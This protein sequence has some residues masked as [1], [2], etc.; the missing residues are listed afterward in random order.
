[1][2]IYKK[3]LSII[4]TVATVV[5]QAFQLLTNNNFNRTSNFIQK[6]RNFRNLYISG[7]ISPQFA[8]FSLIIFM[9]PLFGGAKHAFG[10]S[11]PIVTNSVKWNPGHY[12]TILNYGKNSSRYL[13]QIY[14][15]LQETPALRG[16]QVNYRWA[17]LE[18]AEGEYDFSSITQRLSELSSMKKR[19]VIVID[20]KTS[21][22]SDEEIVPQYLKTKKYAGGEFMIGYPDR[23]GKNIK[24]WN[25]AVRD[26]LSALIEA[27]GKRFNSDPYF[28]GIGLS[29][30]SIGE[31]YVPLTQMQRE[32]YYANLL[33]L[34]Q[35]MR[36]H[37]PNTLTFQFTS[38]PRLM[39][40][41]FIESLSEIGAGLGGSSVSMPIQGI[42]HPRYPFDVYSYFPKYSEKIPLVA[43]VKYANYENTRSDFLGYEPTVLE[44][45]SFARDRLRANYIFWTRHPEYYPKVLELLNFKAQRSN[46]SGGLRASCPTVY[47]FCIN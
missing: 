29:D 15:E 39:L 20:S 6:I 45:L 14:Q 46:P 47:S 34:Q 24:L 42:V 38:Y 27:L 21:L 37:F 25:L 43:S 7:K 2:N 35:Q 31:T 41:T 1:M 19:L 17:E 3:V 36:N 11:L 12:Y 5:T 8:V 32:D 22:D 44:L 28:E 18:Q 40:K 4:N 33:H 13:S 23:N 30:T 9:T 16:I 10:S 26:R